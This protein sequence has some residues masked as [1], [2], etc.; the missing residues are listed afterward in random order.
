[1]GQVA[2]HAL[3]GHGEA[4]GDGVEDAL[5]GLMEQQPVEGG[6]LQA[7]ARQQLGQHRRHL[8]NGE[9]VDLLAVHVDRGEA[10]D[11]GT[12]VSDQGPVMLGLGEGEAGVAA[13]VGAHAES[14]QAV[15]TGFAGLEGHRAGPVA[16]QHA[17]AAIVPVE[18]A[19]ELIGADHQHLREAAIAEVLGGRDQGEQEAAAGG[20]QVEGHGAGG[21]D[22][23]LH[24]RCGAEQVVG[25]RGG[26][27]DQ[28]QLLRLPAGM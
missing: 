5:I 16:E 18:P 26:Q 7:G 12:G 17:G 25:A 28:I 1:M 9:L 23:G 8:P 4:V 22:G 3:V 15:L 2:E 11:L 13:A 14:H 19:A 27:K 20:G 10:P 6:G 21:A 24:P